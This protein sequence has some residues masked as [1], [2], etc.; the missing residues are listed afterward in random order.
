M[1]RLFQLL[2]TIALG[3][4]ALGLAWL[5][6]SKSL[7]AYLALAA[8]EQALWLDAADPEAL[9]GLAERHLE[10]ERARKVGRQRKADAPPP[11]E[12]LRLWSELAKA[13]TEASEG[14]GQQQAPPAPEAPSAAA[15]G[16][17]REEARIRAE[18]ALA[19]DP[20]NARALRILGLLAEAAG[21]E[22]RALAYMQ[23]AAR[24]SIQ[25]SLALDWLM[26]HHPPQEGLCRGAPFCRCA[27]A[28][29]LAGQGARAAGPGQHGRD[30]AGAGRA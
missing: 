13:V 26:R 1:A 16:A 22:A 27:A 2:R 9:A 20:A 14:P 6:I 7:V 5:V 18:T 15:A 24:R 12:S 29:A 23:A 25:E 30:A 10:E 28:D 8:P 11:G 4:L 3:A 19:G 21:D 17:E